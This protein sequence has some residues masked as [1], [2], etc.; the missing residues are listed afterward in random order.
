ML[1][2]LQPEAKVNYVIH[3]LQCLSLVI[4]RQECEPDV[5][6]KRD[7]EMTQAIIEWLIV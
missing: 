4:L 2:T 7:E 3:P 6:E 5:R 1:L